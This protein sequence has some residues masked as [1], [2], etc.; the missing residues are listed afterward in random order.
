MKKLFSIVF[1]LVFIISCTCNEEEVGRNMIT[2]SNLEYCTSQA[3]SFTFYNNN[4]EIFTANF[5][6][7]KLFLQRSN[8]NPESCNYTVNQYAEEDINIGNYNGKIRI[9]NTAI[10][11]TIENG[12]FSNELVLGINSHT[13]DD[14]LQDISINGFNFEDVL[15]IENNG[16]ATPFNITKII[17]SKTNGIEFILFEDGTWYKRVE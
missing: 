3:N 16:R 10:G 7:K 14:N 8:V 15:V 13:I 12:Q 2:N 17:Y 6:G 1:L 9:D 11:I 5:S 4:S